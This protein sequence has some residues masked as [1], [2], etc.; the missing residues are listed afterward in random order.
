[1]YMRSNSCIKCPRKGNNKFLALSQL[2]I[3]NCAF[4]IHLSAS[5]QFSIE[6]QRSVFIYFFGLNKLTHCIQE[7]PLSTPVACQWQM[8]DTFGEINELLKT[9]TGTKRTMGQRC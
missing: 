7:R 9:E 1:M 4:D 8:R 6:L 5:L 3:F 2:I